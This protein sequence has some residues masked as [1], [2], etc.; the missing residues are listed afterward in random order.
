MVQVIRKNENEFVCIF[1]QASL[2]E[3]IGMNLNEV[4]ENMEAVQRLAMYAIDVVVRKYDLAANPAEFHVSICDDRNVS[5]PGIVA[6]VKYCSSDADMEDEYD[7]EYPIRESNY[8]GY[9]DDEDI[10]VLEL[11]PTDHAIYAYTDIEHIIQMQKNTKVFDLCVCRLFHFKNRYLVV[12]EDIE[13]QDP[14]IAGDI[15]SLLAEYG[16]EQT[17]ITVAYLEEY[18]KFITDD[19]VKMVDIL[20]GRNG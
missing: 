15:C 9:D 2:L 7:D 14:N 19:V 6:L 17:G 3:S 18:G 13:D 10:V 11:H 5:K 1:D 16:S 8:Y 20:E 12:V 4:R